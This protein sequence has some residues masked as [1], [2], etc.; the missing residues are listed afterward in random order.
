VPYILKSEFFLDKGAEISYMKWISREMQL[1]EIFP[2]K[3]KIICYTIKKS[4]KKESAA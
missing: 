2:H 3:M 1:S 4:I